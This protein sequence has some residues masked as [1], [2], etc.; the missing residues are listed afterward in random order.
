MIGGT[1]TVLHYMTTPFVCNIIPPSKS[2]HYRL[3]LSDDLTFVVVG[4]NV[5]ADGSVSCCAEHSML[6][7]CVVSC[8]VDES[9]AGAANTHGCVRAR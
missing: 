8:S 3:A 6:F 1:A 5:G 7:G 2:M 4:V 9:S